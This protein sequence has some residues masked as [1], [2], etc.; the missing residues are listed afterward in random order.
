M[1][2][3][4]IQVSKWRLA[5]DRGFRLMDTTV[6]SGY[7]IMA[8][9]WD[10]VLGHKA[11]TISDDEYAKQYRDLLIHSW[12]TQR[13]KWMDFLND[14]NEYY[15]L[16]CYCRY[17]NEDGSVKFCHR[18]LLV[19]FIKKLAGQLNLPFEYY[20]ELTDESTKDETHGH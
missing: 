6:K 16:A 2:I 17:R 5:K 4:T 20:G 10:L 13:Q 8:P 3:A 11:M 19:K 7:S 9:T 18:H 12:R 15:A 1:K 14:D